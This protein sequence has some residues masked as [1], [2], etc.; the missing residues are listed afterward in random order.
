VLVPSV[1]LPVTRQLIKQV[2]YARNGRNHDTGS[3]R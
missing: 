1:M 3:V 2:E